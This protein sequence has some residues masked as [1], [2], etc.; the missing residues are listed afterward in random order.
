MYQEEI[1]HLDATKG[2]KFIKDMPRLVWDAE[3]LI[4]CTFGPEETEDEAARV[5][6][7]NSSRMNVT[8]KLIDMLRR[9]IKEEKRAS[10]LIK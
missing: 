8:K 7:P 10:A 2:W 6:S 5:P 4:S 1:I 3:G 9:E